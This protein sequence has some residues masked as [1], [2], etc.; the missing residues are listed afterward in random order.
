MVA[1]QGEDLTS[2]TYMWSMIS[3]SSPRLKT[4]SSLLV[5]RMQVLD[6]GERVPPRRSR[7]LGRCSSCVVSGMDP[8]WPSCWAMARWNAVVLGWLWHEVDTKWL[9]VDCNDLLSHA[10]CRALHHRYVKLRLHVKKG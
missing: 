6:S 9:V 10:K 5:L 3:M 2:V 7:L 1:L 4:G 8:L